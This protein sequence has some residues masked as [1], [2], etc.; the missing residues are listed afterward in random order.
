[1][2][3]QHAFSFGEHY[4]PDLL[5]F[6][7]M[8]CHDD[9]R[10]GSGRGF[11]THRHSGLDILTWVVSG[12]LRHE[13]SS[14]RTTVL[15]PG[16]LAVLSTGAGVEH[17]ER[18]TDEGPVR[19]VQVWLAATGDGAAGDPTYDVRPV[20]PVLGA[21]TELARPQPGAVLSLAR[22][23]PLQTV[24]LPVAARVHAYLVTGALTRSSLAEPLSAGDAFLFTDE[25]VHEITA[26]VPTD[27]LVW[28][29]DA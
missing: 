17:S 2:V 25:P 19:F 21:L 10:L 12:R 24:A 23:D 15:D 11:D 14:G 22:L 8:V 1:M 28:T 16:R 13:D 9:H 27:L 3:T 18:A 29:F 6:G 5:R 20:E 4:D 7:P 26:A